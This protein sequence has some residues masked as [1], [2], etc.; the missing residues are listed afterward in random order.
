MITKVTWP[1][2]VNC[3]RDT[4]WSKHFC[5]LLPHQSTE[6]LGT[7]GVGISP[8]N[9]TQGEGKGD[10]RGEPVFPEEISCSTR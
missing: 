6:T 10:R 2:R 8:G 1:V 7:K 4:G 3:Q 5:L 9:L